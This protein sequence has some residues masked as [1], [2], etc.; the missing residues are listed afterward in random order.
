MKP[1]DVRRI[2]PVGNMTEDTVL[3]SGAPIGKLV[4]KDAKI[5]GESQTYNS[6]VV[7]DVGGRVYDI[8]D[9]YLTPP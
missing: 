7:V 4:G 9:Q 2:Y 8:H 3:P 1:G 6:S 5:V